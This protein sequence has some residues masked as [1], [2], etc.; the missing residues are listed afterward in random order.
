[1]A[2][3]RRA[4]KTPNILHGVGVVFSPKVTGILLILVSAL[5]L[6]SLMSVSRGRLTDA[7]IVFLQRGFGAGTWAFPLTL[8]S[9]GLWI[10]IRSMEQMPRLSWHRPVGI[11]LL[12]LCFVV[13]LALAP[14]TAM[15]E[16]ALLLSPSARSAGGW[17][18]YLLG[19][20]L[21]LQLGP[22]GA[23]LVLTTL[24]MTGMYMVVPALCRSG[25]TCLGR[26]LQ[27]LWARM[28]EVPSRTRPPRPWTESWAHQVWL[29]IQS[30]Q[31]NLSPL[32]QCYQGWEA[33]YF[34][35]LQRLRGRGRTQ[36]APA[37]VHPMPVEPEQS[38][39]TSTIHTDT[40][41]TVHKSVPQALVAE[42]HTS[43]DW[44]LPDVDQ[45]LDNKERVQEADEHIR[46]CG[47]LLQETLELFGAPT[48]FEGAYKGPAVT[49]YLIKPG[50]VERQDG[51]G[52]IHRTKV[53]VSKITSLSNDLALAVAAPSVR[54]EAPIPG[55]SYVGIEIPNTQSNAV[56]L[57]E[58]VLSDQFRAMDAKLPLAL[59]ED[60][61]GQPIV[62]DL[63]RMPHLLI[64][65]ATGTGKSVCINAIVTT[66]LLSH[67]P[68]TL[69]FLMIDPKMVELSTY[70]HIPHLH[71]P[72]VTDVEEAERVLDWCV[73]EMETRYHQLNRKK[74]RD[75]YR[76]NAL[77][78][79][80]G[81]APMPYIVVIIDEMADLMMAAPQ[82][83]ERSVCR[84]AQMARAV[85][86]HLIIATQRP[87]V[88]VITGLI[89]ANFPAR[90]AF[91]VSSQ[92]DSR[93][94][95]DTPGAERLLGRGDMLFAAPDA[96]RSGRLQGTWV[97]DEEMHRIV[98]Y[99]HTAQRNRDQ[100]Q[101]DVSILVPQNGYPELEREADEPE[102]EVRD[103][104][105][106]TADHPVEV[107]E[108][109]VHAWVPPRRQAESTTVPTTVEGVTDTAPLTV[110]E[111]AGHEQAALPPTRGQEAELARSSQAKT[112]ASE[113]TSAIQ[114]IQSDD[115]ESLYTASCQLVQTVD[116]C[117]LS[118][119]Q[120]TLQV[121]QSKA[122]E[123]MSRMLDEGMLQEDELDSQT[124]MQL[125][126]FQNGRATPS[127]DE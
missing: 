39:R 45:I 92:T 29:R 85:G 106:D 111:T 67:T 72:V 70:D 121:D 12:Y 50:F 17:I 43:T 116:R 18:G 125:V 73:R 49:Q 8:G 23:W 104:D 84:L 33:W 38:A 105:P 71:N 26:W 93:V 6:L 77:L 103:L 75:I 15:M 61:K 74:V 10:V 122:L 79:H 109:A 24:T 48:S 123:L 76:Y 89:K 27:Y 120:R 96:K 41:E 53:K 28:G 101:E 58:L 114:H 127:T 82:E 40:P 102:A 68:D 94:I 59:G 5:T 3:R 98:D 30:I 112:A 7:W 55:T 62:A 113:T 100:M 52:R 60:V 119:L 69:Q 91:A 54:I 32:R 126:L 25:L 51:R 63:A 2:K 64:A 86:I 78:A 90:I 1:M 88:D 115:T 46:R 66:L 36:A 87:S 19:T 107:E 44:T 21:Q 47:A 11:L 4:S 83:V 9:L 95:I 42:P 97:S 81:E 57:K 13:V 20:Q 118:L 65:G 14:G 108:T 80:Q 34:A 110:P 16:V 35:R 56:G 124:Y 31:I 117:S 22:L 99:W 37:M